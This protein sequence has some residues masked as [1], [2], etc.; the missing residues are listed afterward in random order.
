MKLKDRNQSNHGGPSHTMYVR[1]EVGVFGEIL[2]ESE[3]QHRAQHH[4]EIK[5]VLGVETT[6]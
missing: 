4:F 2:N 6:N 3:G 5:V 1:E